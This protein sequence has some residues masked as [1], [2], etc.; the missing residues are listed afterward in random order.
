MQ[1]TDQEKFAAIIER[2]KGIGSDFDT[3][4]IS[5]MVIVGYLDDLQTIGLIQS[6]FDITQSGKAVRA[7]CEEFDWK[8]SDDE[9]KAFVIDMVPQPDRAAFA[10][11]IRRYRD[12]REKFISEFEEFKRKEL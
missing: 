6:A 4:H 1:M 10:Y 8:P 11:M 2:L 12:D 7:I 3:T 5:V 9:I